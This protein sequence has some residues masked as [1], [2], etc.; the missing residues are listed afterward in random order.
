MAFSLEHDSNNFKTYTM[1][2]NLPT[3]L[4]LVLML[5]AWMSQTLYATVVETPNIMT[6]DSQVTFSCSSCSLESL[7][8]KLERVT[9]AKFV[10]SQSDV[11]DIY[12]GDLHYT[13]VP[14]RDI[15][16]AALEP[17]QLTYRL[18]NGRVVIKK[19]KE[20]QTSGSIQGKVY[21]AN[22]N[23]EVLVGA[24]VRIEG[25]N[26]GVVTDLDGNFKLNGVPPGTYNLIVSFIGYGTIRIPNVEVKADHVA[27]VNIPLSEQTSELDAVVVTGEIDVKQA[28][29]KHTTEAK[30]VSAIKESELI[31]T[32][33]SFQQISMSMDRDASDVARRITGV[34]VLNDFVQIRGLDRRYVN[35]QIN[36]LVAPSAEMDT[37]AFR[38][39]LVPS[40]AI[41]RIMVY[42]TPAPELPAYFGAG[43]MKVY[44]K[45][46]VTARRFELGFS[47][48]Y[49][50][51]STF[52]DHQYYNETSSGDWYGGGVDDRQMPAELIDRDY[53]Y[54]GMSDPLYL[55]E[56][57]EVADRLPEVRTPTKHTLTPDMRFNLNYYDSWKLGDSRLSNRT[58]LNYTTQSRAYV[59]SSVFEPTQYSYD[60]DI[61]EFTYAVTRFAG[62]STDSVFIKS[63]RM[64]LME[65][66]TWKWNEH[67][68]IGFNVFMNRSTSDDY[69][70]RNGIRE[71]TGI[72]K[73]YSSQYERNELQQ[74]QLLGRHAFGNRALTPGAGLRHEI[75]WTL[76]YNEADSDIPDIQ[77]FNYGINTNAANVAQWMPD[78]TRNLYAL[79]CSFLTEDQG[80][81][82][83]LNYV[84]TLPN[85]V[86]V[87]VGG[88]L[89]SRERDAWA[90]QY[91]TQRV[92]NGVITNQSITA[93]APWSTVVDTLY[94]HYYLSNGRGLLLDRVSQESGSYG[95]SDEFR[96]G[97]IGLGIP[98]LSKRLYLYG[99]VRYEWNERILYDEDGHTI[100]SVLV[101]LQDGGTR[102]YDPTPN[103]EKSYLLPS[104]TLTWNVTEQMKTRLSYGRTLDRPEYREQSNFYF[105]NNFTNREDRG[106][107]FLRFATLDNY[108]LR[109]EYYPSGSEFVS[110]GVFYKYIQDGIEA[111]N[112][113]P[114]G[115]EISQRIYENTPE[116][117]AYGLEV[118]VRKN[119]AFAHRALEVLS[120]LANASLLRSKVARPEVPY[121]DRPFVGASPYLINAGLYYESA[122]GKTTASILYNLTGPRLLIAP[123]TGGRQNF[124]VWE[125]ERHLLDLTFSHQFTRW[126]SVK[127]GVQNLL[128]APVRIFRD[129][130]QNNKYDPENI[131]D[132]N[133][134]QQGAGG[135]GYS[136]AY[137]ADIMEARYKEG[138]YYS[139]GIK[140]SL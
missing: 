31:L 47:S 60:E 132:I 59:R 7:L 8:K 120:F 10:Y 74:Y 3:G 48:Q 11:Q 94:D 57:S 33:I 23:G 40:G 2:K 67:H 44:T 24:T 104:V 16:D 39:N 82:G 5:N 36:N 99:G 103:P 138:S 4:L 30:M 124:G 22:D 26:K 115:W 88:Y 41:D 98:L 105:F 45:E 116:I 110:V 139:L 70:V 77:T 85:G 131:I 15:L 50:T 14:I 46:A 96:A 81:V 52:K 9:D 100:D 130:S 55:S 58:S 112:Y 93:P 49:R 129:I 127:A 121:P 32:G 21:D 75:E 107:P 80:R 89:E 125:M 101:D 51:G 35:T 66:L 71:Y 126:L 106:N 61:G 128:N 20:Q 68:T 113:T 114:G 62:Y 63:L 34:S 95:F 69:L 18:L 43:V 73:T 53:D 86:K 123:E 84:G 27:S 91:K 90:Y 136:P 137:Y 13:D 83:N 133:Q 56:T 25:T 87:K 72:Y 37:R 65:N 134:T 118:E 42:K 92:S 78:W 119:L 111:Y 12:Y 38:F 109:W 79:R 29:I 28:P 117:R 19:R 1:K 108:D 122:S 64:T 140:L 102:I 76:G 54:P 135:S 97:Y 17:Y 6:L